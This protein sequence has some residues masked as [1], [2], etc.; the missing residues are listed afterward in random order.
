V[1][2][3]VVNHNTKTLI[4]QLLFSLHRVLGRDQIA[5]IVVVD[6][7][8]EDGSVPVLQALADAQLIKLIANRRQRYHGS[9]LNQAV[10]WLAT[11]QAKVTEEQRIDYVWAL[12]SDTVVLRREVVHDAVDQ[13]GRLQPAIIGQS[14]GELDGYPHFPASTLM[15]EPGLVWRDPV[16]PFSDDGRPVKRFIE[17][18]S[19]AGYRLEPFPF[20]HHSYVLHLGEGTVIAVADREPGHRFYVWAHRD[21]GRRRH[22]TFIDHPL[23]ERLHA[24]LCEAYDR[25]VPDETPA[26]VVR[27]CAREE[28]IAIP[29][30]RPLPPPDVLQRLYDEDGDI[31]AYVLAES[32]QEST[33]PPPG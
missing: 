16:V 14:F 13:F 31:A 11:R 32:G 28:L 20:L 9:G 4:A 18:A 24:E 8:S 10:S 26:Q 21:L 29:H 12:D 23:G 17:T 19:D 22:Y 27:A 7:A 25:E 3:V 1:A 15:F 30:A 6:N 5:L 33:E 2:V